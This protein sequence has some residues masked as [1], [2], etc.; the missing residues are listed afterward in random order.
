METVTLTLLLEYVF[1]F[2][3]FWQAQTFDPQSS[4][5]SYPGYR[6]TCESNERAPDHLT[7]ESNEGA[8]VLSIL[9]GMFAVSLVLCKALYY[10]YALFILD[11]S[12]VT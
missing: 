8:P 11:C 7:C 6:L 1:S 5:Q 4:V 2:T 10:W 3:Y 9:H 12:A